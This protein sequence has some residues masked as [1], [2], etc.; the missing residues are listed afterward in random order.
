MNNTQEVS[1]SIC[2]KYIPEE[3]FKKGAVKVLVNNY[4]TKYTIPFCADCYTKELEED[5]KF[6]DTLWK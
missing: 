5:K 1:C 4:N 6:Y 3:S 2:G